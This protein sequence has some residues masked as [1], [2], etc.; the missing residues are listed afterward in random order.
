MSAMRD[1][2]PYSRAFECPVR[3]MALSRAT[4]SLATIART[5]RMGSLATR[6]LRS[7]ADAANIGAVDGSTA[8]R[9]L[10]SNRAGACGRQCRSGHRRRLSTA[11]VRRGCPAFHRGGPWPS[12]GRGCGRHRR[13]I[14][15][16][17]YQGEPDVRRCCCALEWYL[18]LDLSAPEPY[19]PAPE[20]PRLPRRASMAST[21]PHAPSVQPIRA[22]LSHSLSRFSATSRNNACTMSLSSAAALPAP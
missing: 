20:N 17:R 13:G 5:D 12:N 14:H 2:T 18:G 4:S 16:C 7:S 6:A 22:M 19:Q 10:A 15:C 11:R 3:S 8:R 9:G 1:I 21:S